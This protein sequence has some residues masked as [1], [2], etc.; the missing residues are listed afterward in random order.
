M[1]YS[2]L[3]GLLFAGHALAQTEVPSASEA[4]NRYAFESFQLFRQ[5][6]KG[7]FCFSPYSSHQMASL[8]LEGAD[9]ETQRQL[10]DLTHLSD[11]AAVRAT[12][13]S[14]IRAQLNRSV[15]QRGVTLEVANSIWAPQGT[16]FLPPFQSIAKDTFSALSETL[17]LGDA[18]KSALKVNLWVRERTRGRIADLVGPSAFGQGQG[19]ILL[20]NAVYLKAGWRQPFDIRKTKARAF[21]C[22]SGSSTL[23]PTMLQTDALMYADDAAWQ[24]LELPFAGEDLTM[25]FLLPRD[26]TERARIEASI[27]QDAWR[28]VTG[29]MTDC[30][31][32]VMLPRFSFS[33]QLDLHGIWESLGVRD[34][35]DPAKSDLTR[36]TAKR[37]CWA[38]QVIHEATIEVN[39]I[40]ATA[41][42]ATAL[43]DPFGAG[44]DEPVTRRK[45]SFI[46]NRPFLWTIEHRPT[47]LILFMGRFAGE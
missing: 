24:C 33:T 29:R 11:D 19:T 9:G 2:V 41:A 23:L 38:S 5:L 44:P 27:T 31:V 16:V 6:T 10:L 8:L 3:I 32:N 36:T 43:A 34:V 42:A 28:Q 13:I 47:G 25:K 30:D 7:N 20:V 26:E 46:A 35:F 45:V 14:A 12:E 21:H 4:V 39:E 18:V 40:G 15:S 22:A 17:P 1:K 37:P